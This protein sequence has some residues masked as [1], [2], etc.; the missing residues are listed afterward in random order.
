[1]DIRVMTAGIREG[2][3]SAFNLFYNAYSER[4]FRYLLVVSGGDEFAARDALQE[5]LIRVIRYMKVLPDDVELWR[6]LSMIMRTTWTDK[7][8]GQRAAE[9]HAKKFVEKTAPSVPKSEEA[10]NDH[11]H[12]LLEQALAEL[13]NEDR[14]LIE[15]HYFE[16]RSQ[17]DLAEAHVIPVKTLAMRFVRVRRKLRDAIMRGLR[18]E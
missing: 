17:L 12:I 1:M 10:A 7:A 13:P 6:Y 3:E 14:R 9:S 5:S 4:M 8:R 18:L 16:G 2:D 15:A 11:M